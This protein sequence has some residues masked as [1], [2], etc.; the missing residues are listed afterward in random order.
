MLM[1]IV[2]RHGLLLCGKNTCVR[3]KYAGKCVDLRGMKQANSLGC[4]IGRNDMIYTGHPEVGLGKSR[5][6]HR[7]LLTRNALESVH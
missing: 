4:Y 5:N 3:A 2:V 6:E 7:I 1:I